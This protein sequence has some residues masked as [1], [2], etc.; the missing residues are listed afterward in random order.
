MAVYRPLSDCDMIFIGDSRPF[1]IDFLLIFLGCGIQLARSDRGFWIH[2][3][4]LAS[5][6]GRTSADDQ[7]IDPA[8]FKPG[9]VNLNLVR[10]GR[11]AQD[12]HLEPDEILTGLIL[13]ATETQ[14]AGFV[15]Q[16][17]FR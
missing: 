12:F 5:A 8:R 7:R 11:V 13:T 15:D 1:D 2:L 9:M 6:R 10:T 3:F 4:T 16:S 14:A 17:G